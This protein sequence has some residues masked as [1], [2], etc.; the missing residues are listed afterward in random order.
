M[1]RLAWPAAILL[2][3]CLAPTD[4]VLAADVQVGPPQTGEEDEA[5]F[6]LTSEAGLNDA[7]AFPFVHLAIAL[8]LSAVTGAPWLG[9]WLTVSVVWKLAAGLA[10]GWLVGRVFGWLTF[11]APANSSLAKTGDGV[12]AI[13]ATLVSYGVT[14][15]IGGYGFLAVFVTALGTGMRTGFTISSARCTT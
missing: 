14:E 2:G 1:G 15:T 12:V 8:S 6:A 7:L 5:R 13:S 4:P 10:G 3:A 9:E 11:K